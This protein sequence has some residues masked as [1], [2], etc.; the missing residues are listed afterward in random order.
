MPIVSQLYANARNSGIF[1]V[2]CF[3]VA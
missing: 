2:D 1:G 3:A